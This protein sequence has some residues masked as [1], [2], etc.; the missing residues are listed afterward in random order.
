MPMPLS[1]LLE[2][3][4]AALGLVLPG[5]CAG[6]GA[7]D[8]P[9][10]CRACAALLR[11]R[12]G[13]AQPTPSPPGLPPVHAVCAYD[14]PVR[15]V[16]AAWKEQGRRSL[17]AALA[18]ALAAALSSI[19]CLE[20]GEV[21]VV[22]VPSSRAAVRGRG[23]DCAAQLARH[24]CDVG[25]EGGLDLQVA[26][27]LRLSRRVSD[28]AGLGTQGRARNLAGA[29]VVPQRLVPLVRGRRAVLVD[30]VVTTGASLAEAARALRAAGADPV[31]A[32]VVA[33]TPR[34]GGY[35]RRGA[36]D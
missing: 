25:R 24:A 15:P 26:P 20:Q 32:A 6:C 27:V 22:P 23:R 13:P 36:G 29:H 28:S 16:L 10:L 31:A 34:R 4:R 33:A 30:D 19:P 9:A 12:A 17:D 21:L 3:L 11:A 2:P 18:R 1:P 14:G 8:E 7:V 35:P 5:G